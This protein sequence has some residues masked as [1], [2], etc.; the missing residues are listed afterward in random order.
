MTKSSKMFERIR[1][2]LR[3][4]KADPEISDI[5]ADKF[6]CL[7]Y[8]F[9]TSNL[10]LKCLLFQEDCITSEMSVEDAGNVKT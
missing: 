3:K 5:N 9:S 1:K 6:E 10:I 4:R 2:H 7:R 8:F